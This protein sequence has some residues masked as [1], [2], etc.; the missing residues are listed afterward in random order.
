MS[1]SNLADFSHWVGGAQEKVKWVARSG[2][3]AVSHLHPPEVEYHEEDMR[4]S[5]S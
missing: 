2:V 1:I 4:N 3:M 5:F